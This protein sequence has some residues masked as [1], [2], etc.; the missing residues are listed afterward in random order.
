MGCARAWLCLPGLAA[1]WLPPEQGIFDFIS[2]LSTWGQCPPLPIGTDCGASTYPILPSS[3][4]TGF[5][6]TSNLV[7]KQL[8]SLVDQQSDTGAFPR[9]PLTH[10]P[11]P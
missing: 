6:I 4:G 1:P 5:R 2:P 10:A 3:F 11:A 9:G 7:C 8:L